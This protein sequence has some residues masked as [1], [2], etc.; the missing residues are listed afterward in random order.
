MILVRDWEGRNAPR[1]LERRIDVHRGLLLIV[2]MRPVERL[3]GA[4][5]A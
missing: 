1:I 3:S 4:A 5:Q 2:I